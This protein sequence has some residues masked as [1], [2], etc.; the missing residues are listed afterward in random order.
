MYVCVCVRAIIKAGQLVKLLIFKV[1]AVTV[2]G[3]NGCVRR[4]RK[5][6]C[7]LCSQLLFTP[8]FTDAFHWTTSSF[9]IP[10]VSW[11]CKHYLAKQGASCLLLQYLLVWVCWSYSQLYRVRLEKLLLVEQFV[12]PLDAWKLLFAVYFFVGKSEK[13]SSSLHR[14]QKVQWKFKY[15]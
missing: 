11:C 4:R 7:F 3:W 14:E 15:V 13:W 6:V 12:C 10:G 2:A 5:N 9:S 1:K 8:W